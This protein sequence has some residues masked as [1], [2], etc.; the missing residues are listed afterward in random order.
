[1][2]SRDGTDVVSKSIVAVVIGAV[3]AVVAAI[4]DVGLLVMLLAVVASMIAFWLLDSMIGVVAPAAPSGDVESH[5]RSANVLPSTSSGPLPP[6]GGVG[7]PTIA[8]P[9][10]GSPATIEQAE[11]AGAQLD[12]ALLEANSV[13]IKANSQGKSRVLSIRIA[14]HGNTL[15]ECED[16]VSVDPRRMVLAL[17]DGASSSFGANVWADALT[18]QYVAAPPKPLS[19]ESFGSWL[20]DARAGFDAAVESRSGD[21]STPDGWWSEQGVRQG[22][23][24]TI[25][26][27]AIMADGDTRVATVMCLGDSCAFVL[28]GKRGE[29]SVRRSL[30]YEDAS[31]FGSHPAL[32]GSQS[33]RVHPEPTWT[34][35]PMNRGDLL[36][37]ASDAVSEWLLADQ[38]R[39][40]LFDDADPQRVANTLIAERTAGRIVNDDVT[41]TTLELTP[42]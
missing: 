22:A 16:A 15:E 3:V 32:L 2:T 9:T 30:P 19:V 24:S 13:E 26:G 33:D 27:A 11:R 42:D 23:Y 12:P 18:K 38:R 21:D 31:Q 34:T 25:V 29:R 28:T 39:F 35:V 10:V 36:V 40:Q 20:A 4:S 5:H 8:E 37:L 6:P 1:M 7:A 41:L 14:K 17:A